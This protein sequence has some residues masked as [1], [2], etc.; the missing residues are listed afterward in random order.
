MRLAVFD[1]ERA[2][3]QD[4]TPLPDRCQ[5]PLCSTGVILVMTAKVLL[6]TGLE[7]IPVVA[8]VV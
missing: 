5:N 7:L 8:G 1:L 6:R 2:G 4:L 3:A